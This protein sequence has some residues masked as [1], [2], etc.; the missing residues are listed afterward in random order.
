M[1][2]TLPPPLPAVHP[3]A[4]IF[5]MFT[6]AELSDLAA[7]IG[8]N[9]QRE[10]I[11]FWRGLLLDGRNRW[12]ACGMLGVEPVIV[13]R[14]DVVDP[15]GF[16]LSHNLHRRH[17]TPSQRAM[18]AAKAAS[19]F[20]EDAKKRQLAGVQATLPEGVGGEARE[21]AAKAIGGVSPRSVGDGLAVLR[22]PVELVR[23]V[24]A[25]KIKVS[26]AAELARGKLP[27]TEVQRVLD[28]GDKAI[29]DA[30]KEIRAKRGEERR[31][32][33]IEGIVEMSRGDTSLLPGTSLVAVL[34]ADP[35]W[36]YEAGSTDPR[37]QIENHY[38]TLPTS[39][40]CALPVSA[41]ATR[42][43][44][45]F[46]CY[47]PG[48]A[49]QAAQVVAAW[50]FREVSSW[51]WVKEGPPGPGYYGRLRHEH[52]MI[53]TRGDIPPPPVEARFDSVITAPRGEHSE[54]PA[55]IAE[56]IERM[57]P[58]LPRM[59]LFARVGRPGWRLWGNTAGHNIR[60]A[61]AG[62]RSPLTEREEAALRA[63]AER[64]IAPPVQ[65][66][67][68]LDVTAKPQR[69]EAAVPGPPAATPP[70]APPASSPGAR[71]VQSAEDAIRDHNF[72]AARFAI[73]NLDA[74]GGRWK[75]EARRA[76]A[77]MEVEELRAQHPVFYSTL[78]TPESVR[79]PKCKANVGLPCRDGRT[80]KAITHGP[81][82]A[83]FKA[84]A[85]KELASAPVDSATHERQMRQRK[86]A[87]TKPT[88]ENIATAFSVPCPSCGAKPR[89]P[90]VIPKGDRFRSSKYPHPVRIEAGLAMLA[91]A[92]T[93]TP[94]PPTW[95]KI[96]APAKPKRKR[97]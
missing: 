16:V 41:C 34:L 95:S 72:G 21:Q 15:V 85:E 69:D 68:A 39:E 97:K 88:P 92:K 4:E 60:S 89:V 40:I 53:A 76:R 86:E 31:V 20:A 3:A 13:H 44:I 32:K 62:A 6:P 73:A 22:G 96:S 49:T 67:L 48:F 57:Y 19:L 66:A 51:V 5:P 2:T 46:L 38:P 54:K 93:P 82:L 56:R 70:A 25:G 1:T 75:D 80:W 81:R 52:I 63:D 14:N 55:E 29:L 64:I 12:Q 91:K 7:D 26:P 28:G 11:T 45:L 47:P 27:G 37:R 43:A 90:C 77:W 79:C 33:R 8:K 30:A 10:P 94:R 65:A 71:A 23:A 36:Q 59:E 9:G 83:A 18:V 50:G 24:E 78:P 84:A 58:E 87:A 74:I 42:D 35:A 17:L 61:V